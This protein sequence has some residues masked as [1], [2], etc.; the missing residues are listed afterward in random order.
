MSLSFTAEIRTGNT[1]VNV[2]TGQNP[3]GEIRE[4]IRRLYTRR[5]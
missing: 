2:H 4:Q 1:C 3:D 5:S